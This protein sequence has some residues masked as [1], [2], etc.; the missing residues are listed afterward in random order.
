[1]PYNQEYLSLL[2]RTGKIDAYKE[3]RVWYTSKAALQ[4]Y[5]DNRKRRRVLKR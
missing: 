3:G 5:F 4:E 2:A 1:V